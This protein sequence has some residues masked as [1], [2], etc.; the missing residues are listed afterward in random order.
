MAGRRIPIPMMSD[1]FRGME[2]EESSD[3]MERL[4][5]SV[6]H[7]LKGEVLFHEGHPK[8]GF[9]VLLD[10]RLEISESDVEGR[11][12]MVC[13]VSPPDSFALTFAFTDIKRHPATV[14]AVEDSTYLHIPLARLTVPLSDAASDLLRMRFLD[15]VMRSIGNLAWS[16]RLRAYVLSRRTTEMRLRTY[17]RLQ[18]RGAHRAEFT[19]PFDRQGLADY[20]CVDRSALSTVI[21]RLVRKGLI[22]CRRNTFSLAKESAGLMEEFE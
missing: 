10:G 18:M 8:L 5:A 17:L 13:A 3:L 20:L 11:R 4:G 6:R 15:N 12:A 21:G 22:T 16:L 2:P 1:L 7:A 9:G 14:V 19:I